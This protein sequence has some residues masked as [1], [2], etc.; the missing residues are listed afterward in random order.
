MFGKK[1]AKP[2]IDQE[3]LELIQNAQRRV[4]QKKRLY[5]HFV[6]FLIG[7]VFLILAN[8]VLGIGKD[9]QIMGIDWFVFAI[10]AWLF[11]FVY[12]VYNVFL[13]NQFMGK[14]WEKQQLDTI[15]SKQHERIDK[16]KEQFIKE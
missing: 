10:F 2:Q 13:P 6:I 4:K 12:H 1:K 8:T 7:A 11:L 5:M 9:V 3:Q 14:D 16:L 15:V